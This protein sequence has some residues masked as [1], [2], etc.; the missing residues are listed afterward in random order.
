[1]LRFFKTPSI[2]FMQYRMF[3][4][5]LSI[6]LSLIGGVMYGVRGGFNFGIDFAGGTQM[7]VK[8]REATDVGRIRSLLEQA[9]FKDSTIQEY[10]QPEKHELLIRVKNIEGKESQ[11]TARVMATLQKAVG[12]G[13]GAMDLNLAGSRTVG[14]ELLG[15]FPDQAE[16]VQAAAEAFSA[17]KKE[18]GI[19]N[20]MDDLRS[21]PA[22]KPAYFTHLREKAVVGPMAVLSSEN[23]GPKVGK[24]LQKKAILA[25]IGSLI[26]MLGYIWF[27]FR[28]FA[29]GMGATIATFHDVILALTFVLIWN[30]PMDLTSIAALL[31]LVGYSVHDTVIVFDRIR[32]NIRLRKPGTLLEVMNRSINE[33]L[34]R[35]VITSGLTWLSVASLFFLG[36]EVINNFAF[37]MFWGIIVGTYSSIFIATPFAWVFVRRRYDAIARKK[38]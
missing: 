5:G 31:T 34:S 3:L 11:T 23:V 36:G 28:H 22:M 25:I 35:T 38:K 29:W 18:K 16:G 4:I 10:D 19:L 24:D 13:T 37:I 8:F 9:G 26:G 17:L 15:A 6:T 12:G 27:R 2:P 32:E 20:S 21:L 33:T 7:T 14:D 30:K 1:M